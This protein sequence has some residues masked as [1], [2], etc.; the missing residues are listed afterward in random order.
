[1]K[2]VSMLNKKLVTTV[3]LA[4]ISFFAGRYTAQKPTEKVDDF[5]AAV[6]TEAENKEIVRV[7][8]VN[9]KNGDVVHE[10]TKEFVRRDTVNSLVSLE[11]D[12]KNLQENKESL[13]R[14]FL[15]VSHDPLNLDYT[16]IKR[17]KFL[18]GFY[19]LDNLGIYFQTNTTF[20]DTSVGIIL[21]F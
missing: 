19:V 15:G 12:H 20:S 9:K 17:F 7:V 3:S 11:R 2:K 13:K 21:N 8:R 1:M 6:T 18:G 5:K 14:Y 4:A 16:N 10:K